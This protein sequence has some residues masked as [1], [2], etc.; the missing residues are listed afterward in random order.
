LREIFWAD[1]DVQ[2]VLK[3]RSRAARFFD[4]I[5]LSIILLS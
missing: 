5:K 1:F 2:V 4:S 3:L